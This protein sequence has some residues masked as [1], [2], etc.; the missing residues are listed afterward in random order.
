MGWV[1][2][3]M[4][5]IVSALRCGLRFPIRGRRARAGNA[6]ILGPFNEFD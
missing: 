6:G 5:V 1:K 4:V 3:Q 2:P